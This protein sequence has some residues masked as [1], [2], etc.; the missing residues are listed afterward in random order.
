MYSTYVD[1]CSRT[2]SEWLP[3]RI[4]EPVPV[5][6]YPDPSRIFLPVPTSNW[7][8]FGGNIAESIANNKQLSNAA[9]NIDRHDMADGKLFD[10][11]VGNG[12]NETHYVA[13]HN[14]G[15]S[16]AAPTIRYEMMNWS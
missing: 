14:V 1:I 6:N 11:V 13:V 3:G 9:L 5:P 15:N 2:G 7:F 12:N 16:L 8:E 10:A 4:R